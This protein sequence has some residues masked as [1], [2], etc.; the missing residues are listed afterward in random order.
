M[1]VRAE[2]RS[3]LGPFTYKEI[4]V[5]AFSHNPTVRKGFDGAYYLYMIGDGTNPDPVDCTNSSTPSKRSLRKREA[6]G[7]PFPTSIHV[8][9]AESIYGPW[10]PVE[11]INFTDTSEMLCGGHTNPSPHFN[12]DGSV[13]LAFQAGPC[14]NQYHG[15][16]LVGLAKADSWRG[17]FTL[18]SP[19]PVTPHNY[20][21]IHP[22]CVA[23]VDEDPFLWRSAR[24]FHII[25]HGMC[26]SGVRQ[27]HYKFS[28]DGITWV[29]SP[30]QTYH[31]TV[32][33]T[34]LSVHVFARVERPQLYF[35]NRDEST[36][37]Y[38][39]PTVLYNGVCGTGGNGSDF[40]C[41]F[42][43]LTGMTWSL[44]R[45]IDH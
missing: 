14:D 5:P 7:A 23:G 36:G 13:Y 32:K 15:W 38:D 35:L 24:G 39:T 28:V 31:Y 33:Y 43:Q 22:A 20:S 3:P 40:E 37:F 30:V 34:D 21:A 16:A 45:P 42:D 41:V 18:V 2:A 8:T 27:A 1:I 10:S 12:P 6:D 44:A 11:V 4:I 17:P 26:P 25:T 9:R 29:T 19:D